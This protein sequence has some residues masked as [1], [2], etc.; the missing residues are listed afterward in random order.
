MG[1]NGLD[2]MRFFIIFIGNHRDDIAVLTGSLRPKTESMQGEMIFDFFGF[3]F[4]GSPI[5]KVGSFN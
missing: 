2:F 3:S 5:L 1:K 4:H